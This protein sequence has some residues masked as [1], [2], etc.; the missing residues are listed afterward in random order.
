MALYT[1][2]IDAARITGTQA[3]QHS[4]ITD[5][6]SFLGHFP[7]LGA[8]LYPSRR[9]PAVNQF[10][11]PMFPQSAQQALSLALPDA[12]YILAHDPCL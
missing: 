2:I 3:Q 7:A 6:A 11:V 12:A 4:C 1:M 5:A 10:S 9:K 8:S